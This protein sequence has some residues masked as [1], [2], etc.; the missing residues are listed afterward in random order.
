MERAGGSSRSLFQ[1]YLLEPE[2]IVTFSDLPS[3]NR[4]LLV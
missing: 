4:G 2:A 1:T 3:F